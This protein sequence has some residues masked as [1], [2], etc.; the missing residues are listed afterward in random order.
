MPRGF[1]IFIGRA[2]VLV[3]KGIFKIYG[4]KVVV[5]VLPNVLAIYPFPGE[6]TA[7]CMFFR[8]P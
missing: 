3:K 4:R 6:A 8:G 7:A 2:A 5:L 1:L